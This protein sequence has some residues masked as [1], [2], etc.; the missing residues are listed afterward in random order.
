MRVVDD[1]SHKGVAGNRGRHRESD[2]IY[3]CPHILANTLHFSFHVSQCCED[4]TAFSHE[5]CRR[6]ALSR[7]EE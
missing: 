4:I 5:Q 6:I 3:D 7:L 1:E 2:R